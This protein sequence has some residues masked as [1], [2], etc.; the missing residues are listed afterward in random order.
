MPIIR[1]ERAGDGDGELKIWGKAK[2]KDE[3]EELQYNKNDKGD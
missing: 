1:L 3:E 2:I